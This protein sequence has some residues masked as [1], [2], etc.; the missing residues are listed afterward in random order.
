MMVLLVD[1]DEDFRDG[2]ASLLREDGHQV[3]EHAAISKLPPFQSLS[4]VEVVITD[5]E[6]PHGNGFEFVD[7]FRRIHPKV[8][9]IV[10]TAFAS[11]Y[12][13]GQVAQGEQLAVLRKP[14]EYSALQDLLGRIRTGRGLG[15]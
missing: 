13:E 2:L 12:L 3:L 7:R 14:L 5:F 10:V 15:A 1:E 8:P 9:I 4:N 11:P 6:T